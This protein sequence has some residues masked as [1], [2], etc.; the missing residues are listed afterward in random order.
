MRLEIGL[1]GIWH[2]HYCLMV[3]NGNEARNRVKSV[4]SDMYTIA[5]TDGEE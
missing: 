4:A 1:S 3:R 2:V 5:C